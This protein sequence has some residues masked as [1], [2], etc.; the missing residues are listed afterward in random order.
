M[1]F[2]KNNNNIKI[3]ILITILFIIFYTIYFNF[4]KPKIESFYDGSNNSQEKLNNTLLAIGK[5]LDTNN[6]NDWFI[7]YGTLLGI[8]RENSCINGDD[9]ID[10]IINVKEK[11]K[12]INILKYFDFS[13]DK[14]SCNRI[15]KTIE[16]DKY[17]SIDFYLS[18]VDNNGNYK[19]NWEDVL[20]SDCYDSNNKLLKYKWKDIYLNLPNNY[21]TKLVNRYGEKWNIP[22]KSKGPKPRKKVI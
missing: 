13:L 18:N 20:W 19:D 1:G 16:N 15:I 3:I 7:G 14:R 4:Y 17:S 21:K 11:D 2:K 10:I 12:L 5:I 9:D 8:V 6:I 22:Q